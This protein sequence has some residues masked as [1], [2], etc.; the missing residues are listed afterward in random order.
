[1]TEAHTAVHPA[2]TLSVA[3]ERVSSLLNTMTTL[4]ESNSD[5]FAVDNS[6]LI[7]GLAAAGSLVGDAQAALGELHANCDLT[8]V[9]AMIPLRD[10]ADVVVSSDEI[11]EEASVEAVLVAEEI[12]PVSTKP[13]QPDN[14]AQSYNELL[15][16]LTAAEVFASEQQ[17]LSP[18]GSEQHLLPLLRSLRE[19][20]QRLHRVA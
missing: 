20:L 10:V 17:A 19:D 4:Y 6:F 3:L 18:P 11:S 1:M 5:S 8:L 16:K 13:L 7:H 12:A 15:R 2:D 14:F 9:D